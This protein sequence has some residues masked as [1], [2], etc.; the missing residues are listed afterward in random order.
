MHEL[1]ERYEEQGDWKWVFKGGRFGEWSGMV[2]RHLFE[3]R[4]APF[5]R[6]DTPA[7]MPLSFDPR[8]LLADAQQ[9]ILIGKQRHQSLAVWKP[10]NVDGEV[11]GY[12]GYRPRERLISALDT[13]FADRQQQ[14]FAHAAMLL[15]ILSALLAYLLSSRLVSPIRNINS[16]IRKLAQGDYRSRA[17][18]HVSKELGELATDV[19]RLAS[20]LQKNLT[21]RQQWIADIS[22]ELRTPVAVLQG[23]IEAMQDGLIDPNEKGLESL[24]TETL[25]LSKLVSDLHE[26]TLSDLGALSYHMERVDLIDL[27]EDTL[28]SQASALSQAGIEAQWIAP[29]Q[30]PMINGDRQRLTQL[31]RN[32]TQNTLRY[33]DS[34]GHLHIQLNI[35]NQ[36]IELQWEDSSPGV[37]KTQLAHLFDRLYRAE[38][39]R[40]RA[41]GGSG[42]GLSIVQNIVEAHQGQVTATSSALG[43][44]CITIILPLSSNN[45]GKAA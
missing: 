39:S 36:G 43:G 12:L 20:T 15:I 35:K 10:I 22:H 29:T 42:L 41:S 8:L 30:S 23:E 17:D 40:N 11:I 28:E 18:R 38:T 3:G 5:D 1:A 7:N 26:L 21:S 24:H 27:I 32:L 31:L 14:R 6:R 34:P 45:I 44:L 13:V 4:H 37:K 19:N 2:R 16:A 25:R 9:Q 33:T